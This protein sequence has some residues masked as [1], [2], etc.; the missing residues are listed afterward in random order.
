MESVQRRVAFEGRCT[1]GHRN[2]DT[3]KRTTLTDKRVEKIEKTRDN[4]FFLK[5][6]NN[7]A[8]EPQI[9]SIHQKYLRLFYELKF[10]FYILLVALTTYSHIIFYCELLFSFCLV[11][12]IFFNSL[13]REI[14]FFHI[15]ISKLIQEEML[16]GQ[17]ET[18]TL[19]L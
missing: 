17:C 13:I 7:T 9:T 12:C 15:I 4:F 16:P 2:D 5:T 11:L 3:R 6:S 18:R 14:N 10:C 1:F 8:H 19:M